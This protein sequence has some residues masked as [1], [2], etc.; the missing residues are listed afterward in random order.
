MWLHLVDVFLT[1]PGGLLVKVDEGPPKN[2]VKWRDRPTDRGPWGGDPAAG[3]RQSGGT[4]Q[5]ELGKIH[6]WPQPKTPA[7][8]LQRSSERSST[9]VR[10]IVKPENDKKSKKIAAKRRKRSN[11]FRAV[12]IVKI[13]SMHSA[14]TREA[15]PPC[16]AFGATGGR[17]GL[18]CVCYASKHGGLKD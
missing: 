4:R 14:H 13:I 3:S 12:E 1:C 15:G 7:F 8:Q 16:I 18:S 10:A 5:L 17:P 11:S 6:T 2:G 9:I